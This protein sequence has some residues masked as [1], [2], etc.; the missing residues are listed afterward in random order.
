MRLKVEFKIEG[1]EVKAKMLKQDSSLIGTDLIVS[2]GK[3]G[4]YSLVSPAISHNKLFIRGHDTPN[5]KWASYVFDSED[6][7]LE[8]LN[9]IKALIEVINKG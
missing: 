7:A 8:W 2:D 3:Y 6:L 4:I 5:K 9:A 1:K